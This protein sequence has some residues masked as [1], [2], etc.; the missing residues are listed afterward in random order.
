MK[1]ITKLA[2]ALV[3]SALPSLISFS[4]VAMQKYIAEASPRDAAFRSYS[5]YGK[6]LSLSGILYAPGLNLGHKVFYN[7]NY[8]EVAREE[9]GE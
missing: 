8:E 6:T 2:L 7:Q 9:L 3:I 4:S 1:N 5:D